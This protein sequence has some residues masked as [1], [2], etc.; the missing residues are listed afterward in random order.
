M[1]QKFWTKTQM[2][3]INDYFAANHYPTQVKEEAIKY[4]ETLDYYY[5]IGRGIDVDGGYVALVNTQEEYDEILQKHHICREC[6]EFHDK[7]CETENGTYYAD[8]Y[9]VSSDYGITIILLEKGE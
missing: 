6:V 3:E 4:I 1:I 9:I 2:P 7:L 5:G 8:L